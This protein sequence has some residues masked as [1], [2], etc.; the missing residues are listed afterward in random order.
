MTTNPETL[1]RSTIETA[2]AAWDA[3]FNRGDAAAI[4]AFYADDAR[5]SPGN[6]QVLAGRAEIENLFRGFLDNG[7]RNHAISILAAGGNAEVVH[8]VA[9]WRAE[10]A[11]DGGTQTFGG[12]L[13]SVLEKQADGSWKIR[14]HV[15]NAAS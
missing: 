3:A 14:S 13:S 9:S 2:N 5:L 6:G 4:A 11:G 15:W 7:V 1:A 10:V 8:Q 12:I